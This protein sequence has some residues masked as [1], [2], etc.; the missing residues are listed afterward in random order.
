LSPRSCGRITASCRDGAPTTER[1]CPFGIQA[2]GG[3]IFVT[4]ARRDGVDDVPGRPRL[5]APRHGREPGGDGGLAR[6]AELTVGAGD[7][8]GRLREIQR[9]PDRWQLRGR[10]TQWYCKDDEGFFYSSGSLRQDK[11]DVI[12]DGLWG[13]GFGNGAASGPIN[14]LYF[15]AGPDGET[16]GYFGKIEAVGSK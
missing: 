7:V 14:V 15:A 9:L 13:I 8:A 3:S 6:R 4:Y 1:Y 12:I 5:R 2:I 16:N 11:H 10:P